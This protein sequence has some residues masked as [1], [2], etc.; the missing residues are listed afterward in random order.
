MASADADNKKGSHQGPLVLM[1]DDDPINLRIVGNLLERH[2]YT[3][4]TAS[5][6]EEAL[7]ILGEIV[8]RV[9]ILDVML[10]S[11]SGYELCT[12]VK[13]NEELQGIPVIFLTGQ[14]SPKDF[15]TGHDAGGILYLAKP[16]NP[17]RLLNAV[18][19]LCPPPK[20]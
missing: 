2:G 16:I 10:P 14:D 8:P 19:M 13:K 4:R 18:R 12:V 17:S 20:R 11:M 3:I 15:K 9:L 1:V 5:T 6:A 7:Q